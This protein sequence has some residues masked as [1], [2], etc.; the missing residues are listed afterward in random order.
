MAGSPAPFTRAIT[1]TRP[2]PAGH[3]VRNPHA[4][5]RAR[6]SHRAFARSIGISRTT[7]RAHP[8]THQHWIH[9]DRRTSRVHRCPS[10]GSPA[11]IARSTAPSGRPPIRIARSNGVY[12]RKHALIW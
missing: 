6:R 3:P 12:R 4:N 8:T 2:V 1:G 10:A 11:R 5:S 7:T 9:D